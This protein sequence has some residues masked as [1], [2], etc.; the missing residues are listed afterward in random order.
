M[1]TW[2]G[3]NGGLLAGI[4][5]V[6]SNAP[7]V[8]DI[9]N[10][11]QLIRQNNDI[12]RSGA[13]NVGLT[14]LQGLSGIAGGGFSRKSRLSGRKNFSRHTLMLMRLVIAVL[15]VSWLLNIQ[16]RLNPFVKAWDSLMKSS[17]IL[18]AP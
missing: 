13:N 10:T 3:S 2:Q 17:A 18:S 11:L 14:A 4:G 6:N 9:G 15:C 5:G 7:S 1:A 8:N 12:E 16:T